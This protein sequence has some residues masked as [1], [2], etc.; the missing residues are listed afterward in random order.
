MAIKRLIDEEVTGDLSIE[1]HLAV[2]AGTYKV[3]VL[4]LAD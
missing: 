3:S 1:R 4:D 2:E